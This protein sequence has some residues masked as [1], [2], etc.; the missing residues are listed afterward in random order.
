MTEKVNLELRKNKDSIVFALGQISFFDD[1][2]KKEMDILMNYM[3]LYEL[4]RG[5]FLFKEGEMGQYV[6]FLI[7]G[8]LEVLKKSI[9]GVEIVRTSVTN[10]Y[11][12]GAIS[13]P[14]ETPGASSNRSSH[15]PSL[16]A[17]RPVA[18]SLAR[19]S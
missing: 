6:A 16:I 14:D 13:L 12:I 9:T 3:S 5:E 15:K 18:M 8:R 19:T 1:I 10:G 4:K 11:T 17:S 7:E 2:A